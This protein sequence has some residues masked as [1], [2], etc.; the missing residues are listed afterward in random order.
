MYPSMEDIIQLHKLLC[1]IYP[2]LCEYSTPNSG[3]VKHG[4]QCYFV[5]ILY[6][7]H[8][9]TSICLVWAIMYKRFYV[10]WELKPDRGI[11]FH[12]NLFERCFTLEAR[13]TS[14]YFQFI[15]QIP[16]RYASLRKS[17]LST[18]LGKSLL[19][20]ASIII[21]AALNKRST[22]VDVAGGVRYRSTE[23]GEI[24][25]GNLTSVIAKLL[26]WFV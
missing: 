21:P 16:K 3:K 17:N 14:A 1:N 4:K 15:L 5:E 26:N 6:L 24:G 23:D 10:T 12:H 13:R 19:R 8:W 25:S 22:A 7:Q 9:C 18:Y 2:L 11:V 20:F